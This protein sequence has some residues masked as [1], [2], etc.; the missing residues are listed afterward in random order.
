MEESGLV[1]RVSSG[2]GAGEAAPGAARISISRPAALKGITD[3][4]LFGASGAE[5]VD[6]GFSLRLARGLAR[7][8]G[9]DLVASRDAFALAFPRP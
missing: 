1:T 7:I 9:G 3:A 4:E 2:D 5:G 8:A 6:G